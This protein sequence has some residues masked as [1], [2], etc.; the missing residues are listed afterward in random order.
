VSFPGG[1]FP[2]DLRLFSLGYKIAFYLHLTTSGAWK[3]M[4]HDMFTQEGQQ[5]AFT[6]LLE[7]LVEVTMTTCD[8]VETP[9]ARE[10]RRAMKLLKRRAFTVLNLLEREFPKTM[11]TQCFHNLLHAPDMI[12]RWN[13]VRNYWAFFMERY[14]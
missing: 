12:G 10:R 1:F 6:A 11:L 9:S 14:S 4:F 8:I 3:Y 2:P 7:Y 13:N 5:E